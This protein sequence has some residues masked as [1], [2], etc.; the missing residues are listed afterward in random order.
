M[1]HFSALA[2]A[3]HLY[4]AAKH[5]SAIRLTLFATRYIYAATLLAFIHAERSRRSAEHMLTF[6]RAAWPFRRKE[7]LLMP[8][9][10]PIKNRGRV[11]RYRRARW[12]RLTI[13]VFENYDD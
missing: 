3:A 8:R 10:G 13:F 7:I 12:P 9:A 5:F 1:P 4:D 11:R 2:V 6:F